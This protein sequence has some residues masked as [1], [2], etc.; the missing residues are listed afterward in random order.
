MCNEVQLATFDG[1]HKMYAKE[2]SLKKQIAQNIAH[3]SSRELL[4]FYSVAW[5]HEPYI[6]SQLPLESLLLETGH[7]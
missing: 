7:R 2:L 5:L 1:L 6:N 3:S 4:T